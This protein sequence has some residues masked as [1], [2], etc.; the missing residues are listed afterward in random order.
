MIEAIIRWSVK[1]R[2]FILLATFIL[3]G[4]GLYSL[5]N[6]PVDAIPDLSDVQVII[7][8]T[9][10]GQA[11]QVVEDQVTYPLTTAM[12]SVPGAV[13]VRG[14]SFF[15]DSY[16][17]VIFD[18]KTDLYWARSRVLEY[19]S[20]VAP[21]LPDNARP[22]LGPDAT[23]VGWVY[24]YALV[25]R[26]GRHDI[27]QLRSLQDWFLKYELQTVPGV[28]EVSAVGGM[29]KQYQ[30][31][32]HPEKLRAFGIP[33]SKI[34]MAIKK[35]N[36]EIGASVVEMAEAEYMVRATG[37]LQSEKNLG[38]I[39]LGVNS[40]GTPLLLKDVADIGIGPQM[41]RG[42]AELDGEGETVGGIIVMRFGENAQKTIDGVKVKLEE[43]KK[44]LPEG[45]EI[46]PVYDRS[47][48]I[49]RAINNLWHKL[50]E[51]FAVVALVCIM[52]LFHIRSSL[53]AIVS[54][55]VGILTAF[56]IMHIQGLNANIMSLGGIAIAIGAMIDGA[57]VMIEN[58][59][60]HMEK[61]PLTRENRWRVVADSA[62]EVGPA[63]F[64]SLLIITVS[65]VPVFTLEAQEGRMFSPLAFTKTY[66]MAAAAALAITLVP[67][68]MGYFIRGR[69][70]PEH[71]NPLNR[72]LTA[73][74][75][76]ALRTVL[77]F[78][79]TVLLASLMILLVGLW[80]IDKI[81]SE[82]IPPL[83]EGDL[84]YM[85]TTYPGISIGKARELLQQT[86]K[87][88]ATVPEVETVFGKVG[89]AETATDPAPLTMIETFIQ[90]KPRD[91]WRAG[92]TTE[93]L[94]KEFDTLVKLP[95]LTN[96]WVMPI[97]TRIDMLAT[98]IKTPVGIKVAGPDL[99]RIQEIGQQLEKILADVAGTAS[100]Y[101][102][103]VAGGRYIKVDIQREKAARYGLNI[104]DV[105]QVVATAIGGMKVT[106]TVEG[107]ERYPVNIRYPH[108]FRNSP[109]QLSLLPIVTESGQ[110]ISLGDVADIF[111]EDGP[112]AI[113]SENARL[114][115]WT[116]V[117]IEG[118]DIG[119]YVV[120]A[121]KVVKDRVELPPGYS[122]TWSGQYEY[123]LR[124]K[125]KLSYV[126][127]LTLAIIVVLLFMN[128]RN[129]IEVAIIMGTLPLAM[130][131][132][133]W[134]MYLENYNFS[135][136]VGV[137]FIALAG[138]SVE[139]GV[140]MLV[141]L[142]QRYYR[143]IARCREEGC[144][145]GQ[146]HLLEAVLEGAGM[147]VRPVMMTAA[148]IVVGLLPILFGT[149]T[150]SEVMSRIAAPM[151]GGM[152]SSVLLTLLVVPA[153][154]YLWK[155]RSISSRQS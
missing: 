73:I 81:G 28:S 37:Y 100:V 71:K 130:V 155:K 82:F 80:P 129:F 99:T 11:P 1:N 64:F 40:N 60:K 152:V 96:A 14:Y 25:D 19:L 127:P 136:A 33:L 62:S 58:M 133:V 72:L 117:D 69:V 9:Y 110:R 56:I 118:V 20:Q 44:G 5:K 50:L 3:T 26:T 149:G 140:I 92:V 108:D 103:R 84:M 74:Y 154:F 91:Q 6:T 31:K 102:E 122:L 142:N 21:S 13:T 36:Q 87:L 32:V 63:L 116:F 67:V 135:V 114:N 111:V 95:G 68:L 39:P 106:Q 23:G 49:K 151:V 51:E 8:T 132:S 112:P 107:L 115:G 121:Q 75:L 134:L 70:L 128:F 76:P 12:L 66:A 83:D 120:R 41:R 42:I 29:V 148:A 79:K 85:P 150:G 43:L 131:G 125:E 105:Q 18:D 139:I 93:S 38:N 124:A 7:K 126:V 143:M 10:P 78:P 145:P 16:V 119:S 52:F 137:G 27:S 123:M 86:D 98:G 147:R 15:G 104:A 101:S 30:V 88:I 61:S 17:Y 97:K 24:L 54:L 90:L 2:F 46:I 4:L 109:E 94:K 144:E 53:V 22:Q 59:H 47:A 89:R 55:P 141:Y 77:R 153:L 146:S 65:F 57:I 35:G 48:L 34:Q 113:K 45:V 138:V